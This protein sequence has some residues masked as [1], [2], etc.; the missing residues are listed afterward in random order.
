MYYASEAEGALTDAGLRLGKRTE[1][2]SDTVA[3]GGVIE[4]NPAAGAAAEKGTAVDIVLSTGSKQPPAVE[5]SAP[6]GANV[7]SRQAPA[8]QAASS[9]TQAVSASSVHEE[10]V[11][12]KQKEKK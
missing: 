1:A 2:S 3:A 11:R 4:Q 8:A 9:A 7:G 5:Q 6:A 10:T 12:K